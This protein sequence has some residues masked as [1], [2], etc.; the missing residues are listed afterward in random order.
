V[1]SSVKPSNA[2]NDDLINR[3]ISL[4]QSRARRDLSTEDARQ[5]TENIT[6]FFTVLSEWS[7][8]EMSR[9]ANDNTLNFK[10]GGGESQGHLEDS[11]RPGEQGKSRP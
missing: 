11:I 6:G 2:T 7:R 3:T 1:R 8:S 10:V 4:W 9:G 5:I